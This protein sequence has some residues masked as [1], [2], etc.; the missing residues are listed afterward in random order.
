[1]IKFDYLDE[2]KTP[3]KMQLIMYQSSTLKLQRIDKKSPNL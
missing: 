1:M 3:S 2:Y